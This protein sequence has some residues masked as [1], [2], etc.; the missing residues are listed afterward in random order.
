MAS[1]SYQIQWKLQDHSHNHLHGKYFDHLHL[2]SVHVF[3]RMSLRCAW[4]AFI[5]VSVLR[6]HSPLCG[7][8]ALEPMA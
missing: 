2:F 7:S 1:V 3:D 6:G 8:C 4:P 5:P